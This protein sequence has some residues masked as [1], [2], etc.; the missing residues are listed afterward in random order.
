[1]GKTIFPM[2]R[3][4]VILLD[5]IEH[6]LV[7]K[8]KIFLST[9]VII[10]KRWI[11][12]YWDSKCKN[13]SSPWNRQAHINNYSQER[14]YNSLIKYF[15]YIFIFGMNDEGLNTGFYPVSC[16]IMALCCGEK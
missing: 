1:M 16:Y 3:D 7:E 11:C 6:I 2:D 9:I 12:Y 13:Y 14:S 4:C 10:K 5:V 15:D 8:E